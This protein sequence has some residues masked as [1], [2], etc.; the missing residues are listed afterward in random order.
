MKRRFKVKKKQKKN[1]KKK[2]KDN[3]RKK[4]IYKMNMED[5]IKTL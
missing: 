5:Q 1:Q 2:F 4:K 3:P